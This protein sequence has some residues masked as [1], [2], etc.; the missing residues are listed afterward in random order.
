MLVKFAYLDSEPASQGLALRVYPGDTL[1]QARLLYGTPRRAARLLDLRSQGWDVAPCFHFGY[2]VKGLTWTRSRIGADDYVRYWV[3]RI[4][5][6]SEI[7]REG[8]E[9]TLDT[10]IADGIFDPIRRR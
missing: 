4:A 1:G 2:I 7:P 8:W 3:E 6:L 10:L 5:D 9:R